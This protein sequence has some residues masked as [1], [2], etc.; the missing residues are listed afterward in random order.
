VRLMLEDEVRITATAPGEAVGDDYYLGHI[1]G[2]RGG[3]HAVAVALLP[4]MGNNSAAIS[5]TRL[6]THF[7]T[8]RHIIMCGIAGGVPKPGD[9]EHD[10]RL[11]DIVVSNRN[12]VIQYDLIKE[13]PDG[14]REHRFPPRPPG[15]ELLRG[16]RHL[17]TEEELGRRP[18]E[19]FLARG[20]TMKNGTRPADNMDARGVA[21]SYPP[22]GERQQG[23]PRVFH[24]AIAAANV[25]LK[26]QE[27]R[28]YLAATFSV[29]A[30]EMEGSGVADA[31]WAGEAGYLVVRGIC[32]YCDGS[33][34]DAWQGAA[35]VAAAAYTRALIGSMN[36]TAAAIGETKKEK[37]LEAATPRIPIL[38]NSEADSPPPFK[39]Q[40]MSEEEVR[41]TRDRETLTKLFSHINVPILEK[42]LQDAPTYYNWAVAS[43]RD[44]FDS[45]YNRATFYLHDESLKKL[46]Q[47][48]A[49]SWQASMPGE[50][51]YYRQMPD[52]CIQKFIGDDEA[53]R[54]H[55]LEK[56]RAARKQLLQGTISLAKTLKSLLDYVQKNYPEIDIELLG[57]DVG[58][59]IHKNL[60]KI[61]SAR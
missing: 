13:R 5:A 6:L 51:D 30:I 48:F 56:S 52:P 29:K 36:V 37:G 57:L 24:A 38:E 35:A 4:D 11:G 44:E 41:R 54:L 25:L 26:N 32:D 31:T 2:D 33:K 1:P 58:K 34:G 55:I 15:A 59:N 19:A 27:H 60:R 39:L 12:G 21:I 23:R 28:D 42:H 61:R 40:G 46:I 49:D 43:L 50:E 10:V 20:S 9:V 18:W 3:M 53:S 8:V 17:Q 45:R 22:D 7:P 14:S 16:V 47:D